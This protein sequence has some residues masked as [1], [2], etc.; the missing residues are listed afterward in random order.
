M[1]TLFAKKYKAQ[2]TIVCDTNQISDVLKRAE[3]SGID[4]YAWDTEDI[5]GIVRRVRLKLFGR[6]ATEKQILAAAKSFDSANKGDFALYS[7]RY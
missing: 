4:F 3:K 6:P 5:S 2:F 1:L 7:L